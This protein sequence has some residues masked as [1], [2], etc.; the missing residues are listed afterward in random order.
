MTRISLIGKITAYFGPWKDGEFENMALREISRV[1]QEIY[2]YFFDELCRKNT[3]NFGPPDVKSLYDAK[4][5]V[6]GF[7]PDVKPPP[8]P[9]CGNIQTSNAYVC[10]KCGF[11]FAECKTAN[12]IEDHRKWWNQYQMGTVPRYNID[13]I[14]RDIVAKAELSGTL[15]RDAKG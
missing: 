14:M 3:R 2:E 11:E 4:M 10:H 6:L 12:A 8:C 15:V 7:M 1:P 9:V 5:A 13:G